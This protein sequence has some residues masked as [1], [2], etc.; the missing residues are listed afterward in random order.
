M[1]MYIHYP[2]LDRLCIHMYASASIMVH[3]H[4]D[5]CIWIPTE[6]PLHGFHP[7]ACMSVKMDA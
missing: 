5:V 3:L 1:Q 7:S 4:A 6:D 2:T